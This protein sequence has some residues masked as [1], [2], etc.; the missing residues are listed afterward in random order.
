[1]ELWLIL[2]ITSFHFPLNF[3]Q[4]F[5]PPFL[6]KTKTITSDEAKFSLPT[7]IASLPQR[8]GNVFKTQVSDLSQN[9]SYAVDLFHLYIKKIEVVSFVHLS[10]KL[11]YKTFSSSIQDLN[12]FFDKS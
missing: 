1:M 5:V 11:D 3:V 8:L 10:T 9:Q 7:K 12:R 6:I 2:L 4:I